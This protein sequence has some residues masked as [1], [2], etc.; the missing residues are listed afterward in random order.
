MQAVSLRKIIWEVFPKDNFLPNKT[1]TDRR[2]L[3]F[4]AK[5]CTIWTVK[6]W[7]K[8]LWPGK[9]NINM[10]NSDHKHFIRPLV[11]HCPWC[12][13]LNNKYTSEEYV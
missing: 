5:G 1:K 2:D 12:H 7:E 13:V 4:F 9:T 8:V 3:L 11:H 6:K 10:V